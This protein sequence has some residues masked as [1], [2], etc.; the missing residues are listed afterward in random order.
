MTVDPPVGPPTGH[1][2]V[3]VLEDELL[4]AMFLDDL[5]VDAGYAV[6]GP[7]STVAE[8]LAILAAQPLPD[9]A[10][11]DFHVAGET[12]LAVADTLAGRGV[13]MVFLTG[14]GR[15][16]LP[17]PYRDRPVLTKPYEAREL[18]AAL[19]SALHLPP[20]PVA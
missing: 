18:I 12:S 4:I 7:A 9:I 5:L 13:P 10:L 20:A 6:V 8:A 14:Y 17:P 3:L 11:L 2:R 16:A 19:T 15:E 1:G